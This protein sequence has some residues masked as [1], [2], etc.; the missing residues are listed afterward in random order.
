MNS[1]KDKKL[2]KSPYY[3]LEKLSEDSSLVKRGL[4]DLNVWPKIEDIFNKLKE[5]YQ[6]GLID[7]CVEL[8][9]EVLATDSNH[10]FTLCYYGRCL[11]QK[12][13]YEKSIE[14]L[15]RCLNEE[16]GYFFLWQFRGDSY[17]KL[18]DY[19]NALNDYLKAIEL[20]PSNGA[21]YDNA[22]MCFFNIGEY[23]K[24]H[25][26]IDQTILMENES[27][28]PMI[29]KAQFFEYQ[30]KTVEALE[31][32]KKTLA[33]FSTSEYANKKVLELSESFVGEKLENYNHDGLT[34]HELRLKAVGVNFYFYYFNI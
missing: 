7:E 18:S 28:M 26:Y 20:D 32:Y 14:Y 27:D 2:I 6:A 4:R 25:E 12:G 9:L 11:Y 5:K 24:A 16:S 31:Q 3:S 8:C 23:G 34:D 33:V 13:E 10:F 30:K 1:D 22:A 15:T 29:R 17:W 21:S 19:Q